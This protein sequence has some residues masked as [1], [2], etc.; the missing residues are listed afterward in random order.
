MEH[1]DP[2]DRRPMAVI[3]KTTKGYWPT[4][5]GGKIPEFGDQV[6]GYPSHPYAMKMNSDYFVALA[7]TF[8]RRYGV[9]FQGIRHGAVKDAAAAHS[10][11]DERRHRDV[12]L[13]QNGLGDW[14][15]DQL[16]EIGGVCAR[17]GAAAAQVSQDPFLDERLRGKSP[18]EPQR[19]PCQCRVW[20]K[21][22]QIT[23]FRKAE[24]WRAR[25]AA[26]PRSSSG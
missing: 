18:G 11:Q 25:G 12:S 3:G 15:V 23:L 16:V 21:D 6:V 14:L 1:W 13:D 26:S 17:R 22:V 2:K 10:V 19:S 7:K 4:A 5:V 24:R 8:E 20:R 9:E